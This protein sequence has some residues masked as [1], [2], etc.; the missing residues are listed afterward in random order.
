[1]TYRGTEMTPTGPA[2]ARSRYGPDQYGPDQY[3][4]DQYWQPVGGAPMAPQPAP[5]LPQSYR[6]RHPAPQPYPTGGFPEAG[7]AGDGAQPGRM[8]L[9][10][11]AVPWIVAVGALMTAMAALAAILVVLN[12][13]GAAS[14]KPSP[15][16]DER[17]VRTTIEDYAA[18]LNARDVPRA[19]ALVCPESEGLRDLL[20]RAEQY[21]VGRSGGNLQLTV[22]VASVHIAGDRATAA[23]VITSA[24]RDRQTSI[25]HARRAGRSWCLLD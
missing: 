25:G 12:D 23:V 15:A 18:A 4:Q 2:A 1:M 19:K 24:G 8:P 16:T 10:M 14:G 21:S 3:G 13:S 5:Y 7:G 17:A 11:T 9:R 20:D 22:D 6:P